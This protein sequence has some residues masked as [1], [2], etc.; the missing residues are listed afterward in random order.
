MLDLSFVLGV[1]VFS[2]SSSSFVSKSEVWP[3]ISSDDSYT[4]H[5][6][7]TFKTHTKTKFKFF[8]LKHSSVKLNG[9]Q[10]LVTVGVHELGEEKGLGKAGN[11]STSC[12]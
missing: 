3:D 11:F 6:E 4:Q 2:L 7:I 8:S 1:L 12:K 9:V 5:D 10:D